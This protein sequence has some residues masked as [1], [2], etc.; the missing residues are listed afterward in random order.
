M[1]LPPADPPHTVFDVF[2]FAVRNRSR[3]RMTA[4]HTMA[5]GIAASAGT[6]MPSVRA[7]HI[8]MP[9]MIAVPRRTSAICSN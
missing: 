3:L 8:E 6:C 2:M 1:A 4:A 5:T 9:A 7:N